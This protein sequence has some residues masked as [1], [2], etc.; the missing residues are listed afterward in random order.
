MCVTHKHTQAQRRLFPLSVVFHIR[1]LP[2]TVYWSVHT[3]ITRWRIRRQTCSSPF[4]P[5]IFSRDNCL[6]FAL[7][8]LFYYRSGVC[9]AI[10][11]PGTAG[12]VFL[13]HILYTFSVVEVSLSSRSS[14][15]SEGWYK[16]SSARQPKQTEQQQR[17]NNAQAKKNEATSTVSLSC[18][19]LYMNCVNACV[20]NWVYHFFPSLPRKFRPIWVRHEIIW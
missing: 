3:G 4:K 13:F 2:R 6:L 10:S 11:P 8:L 5:S 7:S 9:G 17:I 16:S 18:T 15:F 12:R 20:I 14:E 1:A 19:V